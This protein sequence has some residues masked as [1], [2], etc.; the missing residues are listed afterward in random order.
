VSDESLEDV[1]WRSDQHD[2]GSR[3]QNISSCCSSD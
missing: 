3:A 1:E 2:G